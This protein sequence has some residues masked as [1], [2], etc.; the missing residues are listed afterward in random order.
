MGRA[1]FLKNP[2]YLFANHSSIVGIRSSKVRNGT[3]A[4]EF[5][6]IAH[7]SCDIVGQAFTGPIVQ[8]LAKELS[9]LRK[10]IF[11]SRFMSENI[12][13]GNL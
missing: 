2:I 5:L 13:R 12:A 10:I 3:L 4:D 6:S 8:H 1:F 11:V 9:T 7:V